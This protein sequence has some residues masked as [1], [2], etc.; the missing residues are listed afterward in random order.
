MLKMDDKGTANSKINPILKLGKKRYP[1]VLYVNKS[2]NNMKI[3][4][5]IYIIPIEG[6]NDAIVFPNKSSL[7]V[8]GVA[9]NGSKLSSIFSP[10]IL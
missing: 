7:S 5:V 10:K 2:D 3:M 6:M 4:D 1:R 8:I 9:N